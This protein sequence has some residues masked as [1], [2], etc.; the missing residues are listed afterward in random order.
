VATVTVIL[1]RAT[2]KVELDTTF[3]TPAE[4]CTMLEYAHEL[5]VEALDEANDRVPYEG[6]E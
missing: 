4:S 2:G 5:A 1:H 3:S 6:E